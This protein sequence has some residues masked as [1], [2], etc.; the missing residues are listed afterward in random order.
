MNDFKN[1]IYQKG[2]AKGSEK[3]L[4]ES[5]LINLKNIL[6]DLK[7]TETKNKNFNDSNSINVLGKNS[8]LDK[9]LE[10]ILTNKSIVQNLENLLGKK[11]VLRADVVARFSDS[12][13]NGMYIHQD[14]YGQATM[15]FLVTDQKKGTTAVV[16]GSH[17][18]VPFK[19]LRVA[20]YLSWSSPKL[21]KIT[22]YFLKPLKGSAGEYHVWFNRLF[23]GRLKNRNEKQITLF[24]CFWPLAYPEKNELYQ[25]LEKSLKSINNKNINSDYIKNLISGETYKN[26]YNEYK[27]NPFKEKTPIG[28]TLYSV[29]TLL[30]F[31][32]TYTIALAKC[33]VLELICWPVYIL[34]LFEKVKS[35]IKF[36]R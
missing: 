9:L 34:R 22:K 24:F 21:Q 19:K 33:L 28:L 32:F 5:E 12:D 25:M 20:E 30:R 31:P 8:E 14:G 2:H 4:N 36:V 35:K 10:K 1:E 17:L 16:T 11:Y 6:I 13:D 15:A 26:N 3:I 27:K 29:L 23:H 7:K 18:L